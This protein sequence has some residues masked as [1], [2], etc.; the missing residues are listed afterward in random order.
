MNEGATSVGVLDIAELNRDRGSRSRGKKES[1]SPVVSDPE[2]AETFHDELSEQRENQNCGDMI[3][4]GD[5]PEERGDHVV[6][7]DFDCGTVDVICGNFYPSVEV[8]ANETATVLD[9]SHLR[10]IS[11]EPPH[12]HEPAHATAS[13]EKIFPETLLNEK[14]SGKPSWTQQEE[15]MVSVPGAGSSTFNPLIQGK[16]CY[17]V[18]HLPANTFFNSGRTS[19][20]GE[21][22]CDLHPS[23][24]S[25]YALHPNGIQLPIQANHRKGIISMNP[26]HIP[27]QQ[28]HEYGR[29][30][31]TMPYLTYPPVPTTRSMPPPYLGDGFPFNQQIGANHQIS[32]LNSNVLP[33]QIG[34]RRQEGFGCQASYVVTPAPAP[35]AFDPVRD[36]TQLSLRQDVFPL[37]QQLRASFPTE[38]PSAFSY[39]NQRSN[40][41]PPPAPQ[42]HVPVTSNKTSIA[43]T[44]PRPQDVTYANDGGRALNPLGFQPYFTPTPSQAVT[45][46]NSLKPRNAC[47][48][49]TERRDCC[50]PALSPTTGPIQERSYVLLASSMTS[51][52][53]TKVEDVVVFRA[54]RRFGMSLMRSARC[55]NLGNNIAGTPFENPDRM[56]AHATGFTLPTIR[57][58]S[59]R[60]ESVPH[61]TYRPGSLPTDDELSKLSLTFADEPWLAPLKNRCHYSASRKRTKKPSPPSPV[62]L[63]EVE[64]EPEESGEEPLSEVE[65]EPYEPEENDDGVPKL[66]RSQR[67][68]NQRRAKLMMRLR[69]K[70][71]EGKTP[72][73]SS[74]KDRNKEKESS[75]SGKTSKTQ[76][77]IVA[78]LDNKQDKGN[79]T[80][81]TQPLAPARPNF[82]KPLGSLKMLSGLKAALEATANMEQGYGGYHDGNLQCGVADERIHTNWSGLAGDESS[83]KERSEGGINTHFPPTNDRT[84][85]TQADMTLHRSRI[86]SISIVYPAPSVL[87]CEGRAAADC[88][89]LYSENG[90]MGNM[91]LYSMND[92]LYNGQRV[93]MNKLK[94]AADVDVSQ[95]EPNSTSYSSG[96]SSCDSSSSPCNIVNES[97]LN[98]TQ[99][100]SESYEQIHPLDGPYFETNPQK[101]K[102]AFVEDLS[103]SNTQYERKKHARIEVARARLRDPF[104][105]IKNEMYSMY[106]LNAENREELDDRCDTLKTSLETAVATMSGECSRKKVSSEMWC[107]RNGGGP[108]QESKQCHGVE[109]HMCEQMKSIVARTR[110][111]FHLF[112]KEFRKL[113][114]NSNASFRDPDYLTAHAT[115]ISVANRIGLPNSD[116]KTIV[117]PKQRKLFYITANNDDSAIKKKKD[118]RVKFSLASSRTA[119]I[120]KKNDVSEESAEHQV[121]L[122]INKSE[123]VAGAPAERRWSSRIENQPK[124]FYGVIPRNNKKVKVEKLKQDDLINKQVECVQECVP[125]QPSSPR[126]A[127]QRSRCPRRAF[128]PSH[129]PGY[130]SLTIVPVCR[131]RFIW[132]KN[133]DHSDVLIELKGLKTSF[134]EKPVDFYM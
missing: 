123:K 23:N 24:M 82:G 68:Q 38:Q 56:A 22:R 131:F 65:K 57:R 3:F 54:P 92:A 25:G 49:G 121:F 95:S 130:G 14:T 64:K 44:A 89:S 6:G 99:D 133:S 112:A 102:R 86:P 60:M 73:N 90:Y 116:G 96:Y 59:D 84:G 113:S 119:Q 43:D 74:V 70:K 39:V 31:A 114:K 118:C 110:F 61:C 2:E 97:S 29:P 105:H 128:S 30:D 20:F 17:T 76:S 35:S 28:H 1:H 63:S 13:D 27:H 16:P 45:S 41:V 109:S 88:D 98:S 69:A 120:I 10:P 106:V 100:S 4:E 72:T 111:F 117:A 26:N 107:G 66:R 80:V 108:P 12:L 93:T 7:C 67:I 15:E 71:H 91:E 50:P 77:K 9:S 87:H 51:P 104:E 11:S 48:D 94:F 34:Q 127:S 18:N 125:S 83:L 55:P 52:N 122:V 62:S 129:K 53:V 115:G 103:Y 33:Y 75:D 85:T 37:Q 47:V 36:F 101:G 42:Y 126:R 124:V 19:M 79:T 46:N 81:E 8:G 132:K 5:E 134:E 32:D 21:A 40:G 78:T 58:C